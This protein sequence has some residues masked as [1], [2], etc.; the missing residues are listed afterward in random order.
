MQHKAV[1]PIEALQTHF[2]YE[3]FRGFQEEV[4]NNLIAGYDALVLM[5]TGGGKSL[6]YQIPAVCMPGTGVVVSP[7][8]ALMQDQVE[9]ARRAGI[10]AAFLNSSLS[11]TQAQIIECNLCSGALDLLYVSPERLS[12][13]DFQRLLEQ[14]NLAFFAIDE[15]HCISQW[16]HDFR[17]E[18]LRILDTLDYFPDAPRIA[19][20]ATA[21]PATKRE[22]VERLGLEGTRQFVASFDRPNI[23]YAVEERHDARLQMLHF[24]KDTHS[25]DSG[26]VYCAS[27][28][29]VEE[30]AEWLSQHGIPAL[31]YHAGQSSTRRKQHQLRFL[32]EEHLVMV[33]TIAFGMGVDKGDV[34]FVV[35]M[36]MPG[37]LEGYYQETGRAGRNGQPG[38]HA[39]ML[40]G[41]Q[42][43]YRLKRMVEESE[44]PEDNGEYKKIQLQKIQKV[45]QFCKTSRCRRQMLLEYFGEK[46]TGP[47]NNCDTCDQTPMHRPSNTGFIAL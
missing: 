47:C 31:P 27:R 36:D 19:L 7:L 43:V 37:S 3:T 24:I 2:G 45:L 6:C 25:G 5:P 14:A 33:A 40:Y 11:R 38:C 39:L 30:T 8:I 17:P 4:I 1:S 26:I 12:M 41:M 34:N 42:D 20:T 28:Q 10:R 9:A 35:H 44:C 13:P 18:Y 23:H 16:G 22:I 32:K 29:K 15:A 46:A 21:D